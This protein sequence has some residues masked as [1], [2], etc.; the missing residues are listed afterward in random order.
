[1]VESQSNKLTLV[2][3]A[4]VLIYMTYCCIKQINSIDEYDNE[5]DDDYDDDYNYKNIY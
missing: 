2:I 4:V 5:F 1:M 3:G